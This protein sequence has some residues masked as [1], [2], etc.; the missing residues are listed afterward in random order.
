MNAICDQRMRI[1][2]SHFHFAIPWNS[3]KTQVLNCPFHQGLMRGGKVQ[4]FSIRNKYFNLFQ[5]LCRSPYNMINDPHLMTNKIG[6][7]LS[8]W[9]LLLLLHVIHCISIRQV[10]DF[11]LLAH[12][13][14]GVYVRPDRLADKCEKSPLEG[15]YQCSLIRLFSLSL[16]KNKLV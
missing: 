2:C 14:H 4:K 8:G 11:V 9:I 6:S 13:P 1:P 12:P 5:W 15:P 16:G 7:T 10:Y 3:C